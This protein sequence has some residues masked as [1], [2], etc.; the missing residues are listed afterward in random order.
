MLTVQQ[1]VAPVARDFALRCDWSEQYHPCARAT[2]TALWIVLN[3]TSMIDAA[4]RDF[5]IP[6]IDN[7]YAYMYSE[8]LVTVV[9][10]AT[11]IDHTAWL[12]SLTL[13]H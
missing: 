7:G 12:T 1:L 3:N 4:H 11:I 6:L 13:S 2:T 5:E 10:R 8:D 9:R